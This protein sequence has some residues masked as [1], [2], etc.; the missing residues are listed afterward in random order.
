MKNS[1]NL[2]P[3]PNSNSSTYDKLKAHIKWKVVWVFLSDPEVINDLDE[4]G[5]KEVF[6]WYISEQDYL[7]VLESKHKKNALECVEFV[8]E[9]PMWIV[10]KIQVWVQNVYLIN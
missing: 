2:P 5:F 3:I 7:K 4:N 9:D 6:F 1:S 8:S 10:Q